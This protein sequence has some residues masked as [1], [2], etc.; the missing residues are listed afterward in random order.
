[1]DLDKNEV[2]NIT[3]FKNLIRENKPFKIIHL[4]MVHW[5]PIKDLNPLMMITVG[6]N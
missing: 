3:I 1:M 5:G 2:V 4:P 6:D